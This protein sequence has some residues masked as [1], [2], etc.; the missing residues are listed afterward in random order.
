[1]DSSKISSF[2]EETNLAIYNT[3]FLNN[4]YDDLDQILRMDEEEVKQMLV[5]VGMEARGHV[6]R[7]KKAV[8]IRRSVNDNP[9]D[10]LVHPSPVVVDNVE[11]AHDGDTSYRKKSKFFFQNIYSQ[12]CS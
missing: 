12:T 1:M 7:L 6:L 4:G 9:V 11:I 3:A 5:D 8:K 10:N 2:L